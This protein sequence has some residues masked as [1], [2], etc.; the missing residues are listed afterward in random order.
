MFLTFVLEEHEM[1]KYGTGCFIGFQAVIPRHVLCAMPRSETAKKK[2]ERPTGGIEPPT[3]SMHIRKA[4]W[5]LNPNE[6][7]Y[8]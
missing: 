5:L 3:T 1:Q 7:S 2:K 4:N 6:V 8:Y